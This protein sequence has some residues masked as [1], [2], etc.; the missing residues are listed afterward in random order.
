[1]VP[2]IGSQ[3]TEIGNQKSEVG[4]QKTEVRSKLPFGIR[5]S[6]EHKTFKSILLYGTNRKEIYLKTIDTAL[7]YGL[8]AIFLVPEI[9]LTTDVFSL[10]QKKFGNL[11]ALLHSGLKK[12]ERWAEWLCIKEGIASVVVGTMSAVF[13]PVHNLGVIIVDEEQDTSYKSGKHPRYSTPVVAMMRAK[14]E[15][16]LYIAGSNTPSIEAFYSTEKNVVTNGIRPKNESSLVRIVSA[17]SDKKVSIV[18][19]HKEANPVFSQLLISKL[20]SYISVNKKVLFFLNRRGFSSFILCEDCGYVPKCP[21]CD[22]SLTYHRSELILK[23]HYCGYSER[24]IGY[25]PQCKGINLSYKGV[26]TARVEKAFNKFFPGVKIFRLDLDT[27]SSKYITHILPSFARGEFQVILGTQLIVKP[28]EL[29][30]IGLV[31][32]I[33]ADTGLNLPDFR[34]PEHT[35]S[36]LNR[37]IERGEETVLQTHNPNHYIFKYLSS[38]GYLN[39]YKYEKSLR[40]PHNYPPYSH[41]VRIVTEGSDEARAME[42]INKL[43]SEL[44]KLG[45]EFIGPSLCS[46]SHKKGKFGA[47][48]LLKVNDPLELKLEGLI[49][50]GTTI[51]VDPLEFI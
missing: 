33:S 32:I 21:H 46:T 20:R 17:K 31:G 24:A 2:T 37:L 43:T 16:C 36:L 19:M 48:I 39:F 26:G 13:A 23:C 38:Q 7:S 3:K 15:K 51:D 4:V 5:E 40:E 14:I 8:G 27:I 9:K 28:I 34:A 44:N 22:I 45:V 10:F 11:V 6:L 1:M 35:F 42:K 50:P 49:P 29:P 25:C 41:L 18:D 30:K 47:H 12:D